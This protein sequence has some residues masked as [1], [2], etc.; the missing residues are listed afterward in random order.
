MPRKRE[1]FERSDVPVASTTRSVVGAVVC[2]V[3]L[4]AAALVGR[5]DLILHVGSVGDSKSLI[6]HPASTTHSQLGAEEQIAA[7]VYPDLLRL[8]VGTESVDDLIADLE[9]ALGR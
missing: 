9:Q 7:G 1:R 3:V 5:L 6:V 8:S 2:V 4:A